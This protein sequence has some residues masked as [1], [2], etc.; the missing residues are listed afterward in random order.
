MGAPAHPGY[1]CDVRINQQRS[2]V[3][4]FTD[5]TRSRLSA[6]VIVELVV[7]TSV[8]LDAV[9]IAGEVVRL[10]EAPVRVATYK[11]QVT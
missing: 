8:Q 4:Y 6:S 5:V 10:V 3:T 9:L 7:D 11:H 2:E 1:T